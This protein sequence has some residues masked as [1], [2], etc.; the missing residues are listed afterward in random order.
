MPQF[1]QQVKTENLS[2]KLNQFF[3]ELNQQI[4]GRLQ[5]YQRETVAGASGENFSEIEYNELQLQKVIQQLQDGEEKVEVNWYKPVVERTS[6]S[7]VSM[8][9]KSFQL[10]HRYGKWIKHDHDLA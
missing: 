2:E 5:E 9:K 4:K 7:K 3:Q 10:E 1:P 6:P 8:Q